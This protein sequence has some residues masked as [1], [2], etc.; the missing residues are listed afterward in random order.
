MPLKQDSRLACIKTALGPNVLVLRSVAIE[1]E[2]GCQFQLGA[3]LRSEKDELDFA[4][5]SAKRL[6]FG[7]T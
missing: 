6:L 3:E 7:S 1:E 2:I 5:S 4:G